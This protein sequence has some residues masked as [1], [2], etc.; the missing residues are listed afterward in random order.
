MLTPLL[1]Q[2]HEL[3]SVA[4]AGFGGLLSGL[5]LALW[6]QFRKS[7]GDDDPPRVVEAQDPAINDEGEQVPAA[8]RSEA[9][10]DLAAGLCP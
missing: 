8:H 5:G 1:T 3:K 6:S 2:I 4:A 10:V 7:R 9:V